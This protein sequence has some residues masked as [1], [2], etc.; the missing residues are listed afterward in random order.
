MTEYIVPAELS[1]RIGDRAHE[2][3]LAIWR[4]LELRGCVRIDMILDE[5]SVPQVID[6]NTSPGMTETS[7]IPKA[8]EQLG[9]T[10]DQLVEEILMG[11]NLKA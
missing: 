1:P 4:H 8:W 7:L 10:F 6:V 9:K 3:A 11:A 2:M 5:E